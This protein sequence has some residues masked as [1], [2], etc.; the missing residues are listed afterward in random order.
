MARTSY[1]LRSFRRIFF[2]FLSLVVVPS[3]GLSGFGVLAIKNERAAL[4]LRVNSAL[5]EIEKRL[6]HLLSNQQ[7]NQLRRMIARINL[8]TLKHA[9]FK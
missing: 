3:A 9:L 1:E 4:N 5:E 6:I 8:S 7:M 2:L